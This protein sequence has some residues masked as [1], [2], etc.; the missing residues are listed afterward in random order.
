MSGFFRHVP[1][2]VTVPKER[3]VDFGVDVNNLETETKGVKIQGVNLAKGED[4]S[5]QS[6]A[7]NFDHDKKFETDEIGGDDD[8]SNQINQ[9]QQDEDRPH[10]PAPPR[11]VVALSP[12]EI[13]VGGNGNETQKFSPG[14]VIF[15]E[16]TWWGVWNEFDNEGESQGFGGEDKQNENEGITTSEIGG[17]IS[18]K[19]NVESRT[20]NQ[21][22]MKGYIMQAASES[23]SDLNV[24]MLTVPPAIHRHWKNIQ[25]VMDLAKR[26]KEEVKLNSSPQKA[27][28]QNTLQSNND[29]SKIRQP[30]W[31]LPTRLLHKHDTSAHAN[32][33]LPP[34]C[35]LESDPAFSHPSASSTSLVQHFNQHFTQLLK[36]VIHTHPHPSFLPHQHQDLL[37]PVLA[38]TAAATVGA[39]TAFALV[40][41]L[42]RMVSVGTAVGVGGA[43]LVGLGT[44]GI[45]W[46]V[47]DSASYSK[48][49]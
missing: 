24:L 48:G 44:W 2:V 29:G 14:D 23:K 37:L 8:I 9:Q 28:S 41:Q 19:N 6:D 30:W 45:V 47:S 31:K 40:I 5:D 15:V 26:E 22:R 10:R 43:C 42:S 7:H 1:K 18:E 35:S 27:K 39:A 21:D 4:T 34:P 33:M 32:T 16:D 3:D 12:L 36:R 13:T 17:S 25:R 11:Y 49:N 20:K 46:L 38:Q